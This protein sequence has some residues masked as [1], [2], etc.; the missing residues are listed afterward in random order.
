MQP[1]FSRSF[2][3]FPLI[4]FLLFS[5]HFPR[6]LCLDDYQ[7]SNCSS[8]FDFKC[9]NF[10][11]EIRY[12]F[13]VGGQQPEYCGHPFFKLYCLE[14]E[15]A[16]I[17]FKF[18]KYEVLH[19]DYGSQFLKI[20]TMDALQEPD[21]VCPQP[22]LM[23]GNPFNYTSN[24]KMV[25][26]TLTYDCSSSLIGDHPESYNFSCTV[27]NKVHQ[28]YLTTNISVANELQR[29]CK[30]STITLDFPV[31]LGEL[32][33]LVNGSLDGVV[34]EVLRGGFEVRWRADD[35]LCQ[36]CN[37]SGGTCGYDMNSNKSCC[38]CRDKP[39]LTT[40]SSSMYPTPLLPSFLN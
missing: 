25:A 12:P 16:I 1:N 28:A 34:E 18:Q 26:F 17:E 23:D 33:G 3:L 35:E 22:P 10:A 37:R 11:G 4:L 36:K 13:W 9:G 31:L 40:C 15:H 19:I 20:V 8:P 27:A 24:V 14:G 21:I 32:E 6:S 7:Y 30:Y 29:K 5:H 2:F 38:F 39:H